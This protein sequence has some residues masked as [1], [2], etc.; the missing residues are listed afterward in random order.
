MQS[1]FSGGRQV[2]A[3]TDLSSKYNMTAAAHLVSRPELPAQPTENGGRLFSLARRLR[4]K[5]QI[6]HKFQRSKVENCFIY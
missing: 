6:L 5:A 2:A 1:S 3:A 4:K